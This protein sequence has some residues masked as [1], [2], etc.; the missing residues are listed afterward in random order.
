MISVVIQDKLISLESIL[1]SPKQPYE[2]I[3][4]PK[5]KTCKQKRGER[6]ILIFTLKKANMLNSVNPKE[7]GKEEKRKN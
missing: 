1:F 6:K 3:A 2:K 5:I 4:I 7:A